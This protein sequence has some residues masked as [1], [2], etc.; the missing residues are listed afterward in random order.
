M[1]TWIFSNLVFNTRV[2][3]IVRVAILRFKPVHVLYLVQ[4]KEADSANNSG[5]ILN[6]R[7]GDN[8]GGVM[9]NDYSEY[10]NG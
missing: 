6:T 4:Q 8:H 2:I 10:V 7:V 1:R 9:I 3:N 5:I